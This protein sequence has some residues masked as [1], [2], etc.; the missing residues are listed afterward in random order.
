MRRTLSLDKRLFSFFRIV[1]VLIYIQHN[2][3]RTYTLRHV[4]RDYTI[5]T[6]RLIVSLFAPLSFLNER[7]RSD[8]ASAAPVVFTL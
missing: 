8:F 2:E 3:R 5:K 6:P 1:H 4:M 7:Y